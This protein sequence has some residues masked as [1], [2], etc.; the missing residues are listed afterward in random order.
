MK[1]WPFLTLKIAQ[2]KIRFVIFLIAIFLAIE[3]F[4]QKEPIKYGKTDSLVIQLSAYD[5]ADAVILCDYGCY[6]FD[7]KT[8]RVYL[9]FKRHV[10]IKILT[11]AGLKYAEQSIQYYDL[12]S[13]T[14]YP[15]SKVA[16]LRAQTLNAGTN[17]RIARSKL[18]P[19]S[20]L[21]SKTDAQFMQTLSFTFP[22][23]KVGSILEYEVTI[24][25]IQP[26]DIPDWYFEYDIPVIHSE[27]RFISPNGLEYLAKIYGIDKADF[28]EKTQ[29]V[30]SVN[31]PKNIFSYQAYQLRFIETN[32]PAG[33]GIP[34]NVYQRKRLKIMLGYASRKMLIPGMEELIKAMEPDYKFK[35]RIEKTNTLTNSGFIVYIAPDLQTLPSKLNNDRQFGQAMDF[36]LS[37]NDS[38]N[39][40]RLSQRSQTEKMFAIYNYVSDFIKWDSSYRIL[41]DPGYSNLMMKIAG[42]LNLSPDMNPAMAKT[43]KSQSGS[44]SEINFILINFLRRAGISANPVLTST[45]DN[46]ILDTSYFNMHQFNHLVVLAEAEG[47]LY[48]LDAVQTESGPLFS[49]TPMNFVGLEIKKDN[50]E[51]INLQEMNPALMISKRRE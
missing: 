36:G 2:M 35:D 9:Y 17:G 7:G 31:Y 10:R 51:W 8:G 12:K 13:A 28:F 30:T 47:K 34:N 20:I 43:M 11:E 49:S 26:V 40:I 38:V 5:G 27:L 21:Y 25:T 14:Y 29:F 50:A 1:L 18:S 42:Q 45:L 48:L 46:A 33:L 15:N 44:N 23:V 4:S 22:D 32:I 6:T 16:E 24:P 39:R 3:V 41:V 37:M 19:K